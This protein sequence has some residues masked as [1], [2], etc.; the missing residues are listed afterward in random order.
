VVS[1]AT[2]TFNEGPSASG[3][4]LEGT[5]FYD[6]YGVS[7]EPSIPFGFDSHR[8]GDGTESLAGSVL[9]ASL[10]DSG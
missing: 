5:N 1:A 3:T 6:S 10:H 2:I 8:L 9:C 4:K 7:F